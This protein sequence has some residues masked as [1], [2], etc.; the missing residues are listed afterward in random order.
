MIEEI[1]QKQ[2]DF[3]NNHDLEGFVSTYDD[4]IEIYNLDNNSIM[5]KGKE[6]L[7]NN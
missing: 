4:N 2:L 5:L 3:Y 1:V 6:Q 7:W